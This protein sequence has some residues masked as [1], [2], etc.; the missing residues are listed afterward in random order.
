[1]NLEDRFKALVVWLILNGKT[2]KALELLARH[3]G[4]DKPK[5]RVGL[6]KGKRR[7][8]FGCYTAKDKVIS[9]LNGETLKQPFV[10][11]HEFYHHL[12]TNVD[13]KHKG[14]EK[15][16]DKFAEDYIQAYKRIGKINNQEKVSFE[17]N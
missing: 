9:V 15:Y 13:M 3:Y 6:P 8:A 12:R 2:E 7:K 17:R 5:L 14:T 11:L 4:V 1:M 16:A 10:I